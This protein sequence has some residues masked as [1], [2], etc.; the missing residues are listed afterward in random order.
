MYI[1]NAKDSEVQENFDW[2]KY[3]SQPST[4]EA[5]KT[6]HLENVVTNTRKHLQE[7]IP[8]MVFTL[9]KMMFNLLEEFDFKEPEILELGAATG[10]LTKWLLSQYGGK[11]VL[12]DKSDAAYRAF[13]SKAGHFATSITYLVEDVFKLKS[14]K[15]FDIVC[16]FG[17]IE[18]FPDKTGIL[19]V[20]Q[21]FV[22]ESGIII[23]LVPL[24]SPLSRV[25][26]EVHPELNLGYRELLTV[27]ELCNLLKQDNLEILKTQISVGYVYDY[28]GVL[29]RK[30]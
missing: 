23:I 29:C 30:K 28:I 7:D 11:A 3:F 10:L 2:E 22:K 15:K 24:D 27:K 14:E 21:E 20:H 5:L 8:R 13:S 4:E 9:G 19:A 12:V 6:V 26:F 1:T 25:F 17:L 18:H 16:S